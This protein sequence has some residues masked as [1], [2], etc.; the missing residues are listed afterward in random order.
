MATAYFVLP[1]V[2]PL[3]QRKCVTFMGFRMLVKISVL[4]FI[5]LNGY[6]SF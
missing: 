2:H 4:I 1:N 5:A 3:P 6:T